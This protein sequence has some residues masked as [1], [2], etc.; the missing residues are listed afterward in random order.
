MTAFMRSSNSPRNLE[1]ATIAPIS[2][3]RTDLPL[4]ISGTSL[5]AIRWANPST[6]A[7]FPTPASPIRTGLFFVLR[8]STCIIRVISLS[9]PITGS[10]FPSR[11]IWVRSREYLSKAFRLTL[12]F[13][14]TFC[15]T[16]DE[17]LVFRFFIIISRTFTRVIPYS[18]N[19]DA[20]AVPFSF[21]IAKNKC[22]VPIKSSPSLFDSE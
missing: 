15:P 10:N 2:R 13:V 11:A 7:V 3:E 20:T 18:D 17:A 4:K 19:K 14:L 1:P 9:R 8:Q 6:I 12:L 22:S 5:F 16:V 21:K